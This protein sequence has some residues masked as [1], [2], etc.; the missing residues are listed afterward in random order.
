MA[1]LLPELI[2]LIISDRATSLALALVNKQYNDIVTPILYKV[3]FLN[4][5]DA[6]KAFS[7][8]MTSGHPKL[9]QYPTYLRIYERPVH[10]SWDGT[11]PDNLI[12]VLKQ[13][14]MHVP[15]LSD[16][17]LQVTEPIVHY[18]IDEPRYPFKLRRLEMPP[19]R[20]AIFAEFLR[21]Q[22]E[23]EHISLWGRPDLGG[24]LIDT[25]P[26]QPDILPKLRLI[27]G[28]TTSIS[29]IVPLRPVTEVAG[30]AGKFDRVS[31]VPGRFRGSWARLQMF[32]KAQVLLEIVAEVF[33]VDLA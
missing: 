2:P 23:I 33:T 24:S 31:N 15:N 29:I 22:P 5:I 18:I 9:C 27:E 16:L 21:T 11:D 17:T 12:P 20:G 30:T 13:V 19:V 26:L 3:I 1:N 28:D 14:L 32:S 8:T 6:I 4:G 10:F 7:D 25:T